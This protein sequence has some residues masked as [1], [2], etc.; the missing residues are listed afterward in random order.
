MVPVIIM[1]FAFVG[2]GLISRRLG[3]LTYAAMGVIILIYMIY[4]YS[5]G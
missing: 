4:A 2:L 3:R 1:L 5:A